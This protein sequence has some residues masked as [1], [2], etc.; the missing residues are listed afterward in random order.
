MAEK[1]TLYISTAIDYVNAQAHLGHALEKIQADA[2]ARYYR[3]QG[4]EVFFLT[5]TDEHSLSTVRAAKAKNLSVEKFVDD[6][7]KK[8]KDLKEI[9]N[10]T[11]DDFIRT[12]E[13]RHAQAVKKLWKKVEKD[14]Y[15]KKY[16]GLFCANCETYYKSDEA[17]EN[18]CP[19]HGIELEISEEENYFFKLSR[20]QKQLLKLIESDELKII[21]E[22]RKNE[23][24]GFIN[25]G[26]DDIC[27]SRSAERSQGWGLDVPGDKNQKIW[28][29]FDALTNYISALDYGKNGQNF[30]YWWTDNPTKIHFIG[31]D[32]LRFH[33]VYWPA[34]L[35]SA[36]LPL[37]QVVFTHGFLSIEGQKMSKSK[38]VGVDPVKLVKDYGADAVR[39][40][41]LRE[42]PATKDGDFSLQKFK[43]R[44]NSDLASGLGN[45]VSRVS[46]LAR[47]MKVSAELTNPEAEQAIQEVEE[48]YHEA[49]ARYDM[50]EALM[51]VWNL[52]AFCDQYIEQEEPWKKEQGAEAAVQNL[53]SVINKISE[54]LDPFLPESSK[55]IQEYVSGKKKAESLFPRLK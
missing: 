39:Y 54:L 9:L 6:Q 13:E 50:R 55:Q 8:F 30:K 41:L 17:P 11:T 53:L 38:G 2:I 5:G 37:P 19:V 34:F 44:Y 18:L 27:I 36:G 20:Y 42:I 24:L 51:T 23:V 4:R 46:K 7:A 21:P 22:A 3:L 40:F 45:L 16:K 29:W 10:L 47:E 52:I 25:Q 26:L 49:M 1:K 28:C 15:L 43:E 48:E 32:I 12:G 31:K 33:C 35:L 14:I